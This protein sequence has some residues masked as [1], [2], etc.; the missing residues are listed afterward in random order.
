[1]VYVDK[2]DVVEPTMKDIPSIVLLDAKSKYF[3][4]DNKEKAVMVFVKNRQINVDSFEE[5][6]EA[7]LVFDLKGRVLYK[8]DNIAKKQFFAT[9]F[10]PTNQILI[11]KTI[12]SNAA[13][14]TDKLFF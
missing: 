2:L 11:V 8:K 3:S 10:L 6:I 9:D 1:L 12:L 4:I 13:I 7:V 5:N 14:K